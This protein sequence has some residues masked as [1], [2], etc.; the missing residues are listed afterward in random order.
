MVHGTFW[1]DDGGSRGLSFLLWGEPGR[2]AWK[3]WGL[4]VLICV[5][6]S[7]V[8]LPQHCWFLPGRH[9]RLRLQGGSA[10]SGERGWWRKPTGTPVKEVDHVR[11]VVRGFE[12]KANGARSD[13]RHRNGVPLLPGRPGGKTAT[14]EMVNRL[15]DEEEFLDPVTGQ[16]TRDSEAEARCSGVVTA[17]PKVVP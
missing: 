3:G 8:G 17:R 6:L 15:R 4:L 10:G 12:V 14:M 2:G 5:L 13:L 9:A 1:L 11:G 7:A 16:R